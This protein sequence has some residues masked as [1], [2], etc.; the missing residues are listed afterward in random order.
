MI[1]FV[2]LGVIAALAWIEWKIIP[3]AQSHLVYS[4]K[5][6]MRLVEPGEEITMSS[7]LANS[8]RFP[9]MYINLSESLFPESKVNEEE[10]WISTHLT[11]G[12]DSLSA[13][14]RL[15]LLPDQKFSKQIHF[16][17]PRRGVFNNLKYYLE[18]GDFLG[19]RSEVKTY[20]QKGEIVVMPRYSDNEKELETLGGFIGEISVRR[21][22]LED[23]VL[24]IGVRDYTGR[25]PLKNISWYQSARMGKLQVKKPDYTVD[26]NVA[27]LLDMESNDKEALEECLRLV[28]SACQQLEDKHIPYSFL[29]NGDTGQL[30]EGMGKIHINSI[31]E[32]LGRSR[33]FCV[34]PFNSYVEKCLRDNHDNRSYIV[35]TADVTDRNEWGIRQL[36]RYS[37]HEICILK[38]GSHDSRA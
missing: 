36:Q 2:I 35:I 26:T 22:I 19:F 20:P 14:Y 1:V 9:V 13:K 15:Y 16:S 23:P 10:S 5:L 21:F 7:Q 11:R 34:E 18:V 12:I 28:R 33:L 3:A 4:S 29:S 30:T 6:D 38:G 8:A 24:T 17:L 27:I 32:R 31:M 25:E 37:D